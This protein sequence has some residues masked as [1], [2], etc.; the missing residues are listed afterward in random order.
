[1]RHVVAG[2]AGHIDHGK[3]SLVLAL[4]G[5][6]PD[7]LKEEKERGITI[8]I[9]F[10]HLEVAEGLT[11]GVV[12]VPG[13][14]RFVRNMLAGVGGID[15]AMLVIAADEGVMPQTREHLAICQLLRIPR[16]IVVLTKADL[17]EPEWLEL[18]REDVRGF[19]RGTFLA[20]AP[21]LNVSAKTGEG[22]PALREA[23]A[24]VAREVPPRGVDATFRLPIDRVFTIRGFGTVVTGTVAAGQLSLDERVEIYPRAIQAKVRGIQTHGRSVSTAVAG[25]RAAVNLQGIER[26]ALERGDV[27]SL[28]IFSSRRTCSTPRASS[29]PTRRRRSG[30]ASACAFTSGRA[31]SWRACTPWTAR[32]SSR[33]RPATSSS[34]WRGRWSPCRAIAT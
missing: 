15:L 13:H 22:M 19:L 7:R 9:G 16:G 18:V 26:A 21:M 30:R 29:C 17:T 6:D 10:A 25:Q 4:T 24:A 3:S 5:I 32:P 27:L 11:V 2:T 14:E 20:D 34:D 8:D 33:G 12:D 23:L 28:P 1:M 31:R